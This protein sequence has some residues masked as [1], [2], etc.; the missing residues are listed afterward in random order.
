M[1]LL[2]SQDLIFLKFICSFAFGELAEINLDP[3]SM[4]NVLLGSFACL[5]NV[6][7]F[8]LKQRK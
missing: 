8:V 7:F 1:R 6:T 5:T 3:I 4:S 2:I